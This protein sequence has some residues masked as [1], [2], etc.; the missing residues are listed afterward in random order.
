MYDDGLRRKLFNNL[1]CLKLFQ[2]H[3][4]RTLDVQFKIKF[5]KLV[6]TVQTN[7]MQKVNPS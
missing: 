4:A 2:A 5:L 7:N 1:G 3:C 6:D